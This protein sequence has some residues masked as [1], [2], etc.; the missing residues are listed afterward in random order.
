MRFRTTASKVWIVDAAF[1]RLTRAS[2]GP[3]GPPRAVKAVAYTLDLSRID[4]APLQADESVAVH[5]RF[6][7]SFQT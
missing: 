6:A 2:F 4:K 3:E 5:D 7:A 1:P